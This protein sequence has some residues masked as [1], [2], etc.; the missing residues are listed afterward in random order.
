MKSFLLLMVIGYGVAF[1]EAGQNARKMAKEMEGQKLGYWLHV[2]EG[3]APA[4][5]WPVLLFLHGAGERGD[6]LDRV[7]VHGPPK[8]IQKV[9]ELR[10]AVVISPQCPR[11][12]WWIARTLMQLLREVIDGLGDA[13]DVNRVY[14][15]GLSMGG[16]GTWRLAADHPA[17]FAA[18]APICGSGD[19]KDG[20]TLASMPI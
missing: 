20:A 3:E 10:N 18:A 15:T 11:E 2:P 9:D 6:N 5:G 13:V 19:P 16:Y 12:S 14:V 17:M 8:L 7:K 1:V 4:G